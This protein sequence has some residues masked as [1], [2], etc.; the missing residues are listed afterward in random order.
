MWE[1]LLGLYEKTIWRSTGPPYAVRWEDL[2]FF[3]AETFW[4]YVEDLPFSENPSDILWKDF[5]DFFGKTYGTTNRETNRDLL[6]GESSGLLWGDPL[7]RYYFHLI[8]YPS[9]V[10]SKALINFINLSLKNIW[11]STQP[12]RHQKTSLP[13]F[14]HHPLNTLLLNTL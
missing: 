2:V 13:S 11:L 1:D 14:S 8:L 9:E 10:C 3:S 6:I 12:I 7:V 4:S 5:L